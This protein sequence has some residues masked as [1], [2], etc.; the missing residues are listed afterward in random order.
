ME[1]YGD[2]FVC[3]RYCIDVENNKRAKTVE[4]IVDEYELKRVERTPSNKIV[5][6]RI[7]YGEIELARLV[8][9]AG[10]R[11]NR[12][13]RYWELAYGEARALGLEDR[14]IGTNTF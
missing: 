6:L 13:G 9:G 4:I 5:H 3:L 2:R 14:I 11:W 10:G 8:K 7:E 12:A 1:R